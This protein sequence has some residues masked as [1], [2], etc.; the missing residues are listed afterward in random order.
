MLSYQTSSWPHVMQAEAGLTIDR[1]SGTRAT[2][3]FRKLPI[4]RPGANAKAAIAKLN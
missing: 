4:A 1:R 2:T 3:T